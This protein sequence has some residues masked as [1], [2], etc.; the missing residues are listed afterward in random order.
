M[1]AGQA[2][3]KVNAA[4]QVTLFERALSLWDR[5]PDAETVAGL[6]RIELT[7]LLGQAAMQQ[8]DLE[9][10]YRYPAMVDMLEPTTD[11][12]VG[13]RAYPPGQPVRSSCR[14]PLGPEE[15]IR[16]A[17]ECRR[18]PERDRAWPVAQTQLHNRSDRVP[19]GRLLSRVRTQRSRPPEPRT[20]PKPWSGA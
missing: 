2:A 11:R 12:L 4:E 17:V 9:G 7:V 8:Q 10:W 15:A 20:V 19:P 1:R 14:T 3:Q 18:G 16:L 6:T 13:S 5:V